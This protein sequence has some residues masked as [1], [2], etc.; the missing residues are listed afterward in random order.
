MAQRAERLKVIPAQVAR[1]SLPQGNQAA[2]P[3]MNTPARFSKV[4]YQKIHMKKYLVTVS[5]EVCADFEVEANTPKSA[6]LKV[7][8][9]E[10]LSDLEMQSD[11]WCNGHRGTRK[12]SVVEQLDE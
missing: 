5:K 12:A 3:A 9:T 6:E 10:F 2:N 1:G 4:E 11:E 8:R 7:L